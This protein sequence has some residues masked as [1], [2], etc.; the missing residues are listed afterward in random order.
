MRFHWNIYATGTDPTG[1]QFFVVDLDEDRC[2]YEYGPGYPPPRSFAAVLML[3]AGRLWRLRPRGRAT[4]LAREFAP[5]DLARIGLREDERLRPVAPNAWGMQRGC[6]CVHKPLPSWLLKRDMATPAPVAHLLLAWMRAD[7]AARMHKAL[8]RHRLYDPHAKAQPWDRSQPA[9][10][11]VTTI[12]STDVVVRALDSGVLLERLQ[13]GLERIYVSELALIRAPRHR[14]ALTAL[15]R[16]F[17]GRLAIVPLPEGDAAGVAFRRMTRPRAYEYASVGFWLRDQYYEDFAYMAPF[18]AMALRVGN[19]PR[20]S[21]GLLWAHEWIVPFEERATLDARGLKRE[22]AKA[23]LQLR[24][25]NKGARDALAAVLTVAQQA[26]G[27]CQDD[28]P[29]AS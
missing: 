3:E 15:A 12:P 29:E 16:R 17:A 26:I 19:I 24:G 7:N 18:P 2:G 21:K 20:G 10:A 11:A 6:L 23:A 14:P 28:Q 22:A 8:Q 25:Q 5:L 9:P 1:R 13:R 27:D 4:L